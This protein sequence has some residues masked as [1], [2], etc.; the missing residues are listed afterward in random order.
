M[1]SG[2]ARFISLSRGDPV[3]VFLHDVGRAHVHE[4]P[5]G[6]DQQHQV[7]DLAENAGRRE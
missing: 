4:Q 2:A 6:D 7:V 3:H 5:A 1:V